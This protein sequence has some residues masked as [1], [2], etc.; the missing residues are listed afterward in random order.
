M[1]IGLARPRSATAIASK[2]TVVP[3]DAVMPMRHAEDDSTAPA[4]PASSAGQRHR[5]H[6]QGARAHA[7]VPRGV[8]IG[9]RPS[10]SRSPASSGYRSHWTTSTAARSAI[11]MPGVAVA[12]D[13]DRAA[14]ALPTSAVIGDGEPGWSQ[15]AAD[16]RGEDR[17]RDVVEH[18]RGDDLVGAGE[19]LEDARDE[20]PERPRQHPGQRARAGSAISGGASLSAAPTATAA[21]APIRNWPWAPML[22]RP[23]LKPRPTDRPPRI[24]GV[25]ATSVL[26]MAVLAAEAPSSRAA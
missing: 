12:A 16:Q 10:G 6:D 22:N 13:D 1:P 9:A 25:A 3:N 18:D 19:R 26:T 24:S 23:A 15:R 21:S 20:A 2:P 14:P 11:R 7:G 8:G 5:Q 17:D 4:S